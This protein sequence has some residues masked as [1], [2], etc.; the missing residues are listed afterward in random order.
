V[1]RRPPLPIPVPNPKSAPPP[2]NWLR[3]AGLVAC[4]AVLAADVLTDRH[5]DGGIA[6]YLIAYTVVIYGPELVLSAP[7]AIR[8]IFK[9]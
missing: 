6:A 8:A 4:T 3:L 1:P 5:L 2:A 7:D 9:R